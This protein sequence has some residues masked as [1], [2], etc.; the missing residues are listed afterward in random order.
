MNTRNTIL[1]LIALTLTACSTLAQWT[2]PDKEKKWSHTKEY[3]Q[4]EGLFWKS[5]HSGQYQNI[6][7]LLELF[8]RI[9][10]ENPG[11][12]KAAARIGFLHTWALSERRRMKVIP[13]T[14]IDHAS[15]C[16]KYFKEAYQLK[17]DP[18]YLGFWASCTLAEAEIHGQER[19]LRK[20]FFMMKDA[21]SD[22]PQFNY[23]TGGY[24]LSN[25]KADDD[26]LDLAIDWQWK[27]LDVC[28]GESVNRDNPD[29]SQYM[30]Q[31]TKKGVMRACWNS[32]KAPH[33]FE[34]FFLN[35]GDLLVKKGKVETAKKIYKNAKLSKNY[36]TWPYRQVLENRIAQADK[37][38]EEFRKEFKAG[39]IPGHPMMM[40]NTSYSCMACHQK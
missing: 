26:L 23:F 7:G 39:E 3:R 11:H 40:F 13:A 8:K 33:N 20:G 5:F 4:A 17:D 22:W 38:V 28:T 36:S 35:M 34:G 19:D 6:P 12:Y 16:Q 10:S 21:I 15:L 1:G 32:K 31:E 14:I 29:Y 9:Y 25:R 24:V 30:N 18:R 2:A 27:N 37:N